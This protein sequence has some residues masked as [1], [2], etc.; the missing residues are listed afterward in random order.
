MSDYGF[1]FAE[2]YGISL[3]DAYEEL[4]MG[5]TE[6]AIDYKDARKKRV[7]RMVDP[8]SHATSQ[9]LC[10]PRFT[11][12][13]MYPFAYPSFQ[14]HGAFGG[15]PSFQQHAAFGGFHQYG[16]HSSNG[17][18]V[19]HEA[20]APDNSYIAFLKKIKC[21]WNGKI[22]MLDGK[23][24]L[25][26]SLDTLMTASGLEKGNFIEFLTKK[27]TRATLFV[28]NER[29][30]AV[31]QAEAVKDT[32]IEVKDAVIQAE[33]IMESKEAVVEAKDPEDVVF[34]SESKKRRVDEVQKISKSFCKVLPN[35]APFD[36]ESSNDLLFQCLYIHNDDGSIHQIGFD[37]LVKMY[38]EQYNQK[39]LTSLSSS[40]SSLSS[41]STSTSTLPSS[42]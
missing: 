23:K 5:L 12:P 34:V 4:A 21:S 38:K 29:A 41:T 26:S 39:I 30:P 11:H 36:P 27:E 25:P 3:N 1:N 16:Q 42:L 7:I 18:F 32:V 28:K 14:Q 20:I 33:A 2:M 22:W 19:K 9:S 24:I 31:I 15:Y 17:E 40:A 37:Y 8:Q 35:T 10:D 13:S 6:R